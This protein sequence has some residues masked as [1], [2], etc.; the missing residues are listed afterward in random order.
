M[1][2]WMDGFR[3]QAIQSPATLHLLLVS[4]IRGLFEFLSLSFPFCTPDGPGSCSYWHGIVFRL[5]CTQLGDPPAPAPG[6][7]SPIF[8]TVAVPRRTV[9][10]SRQKMFISKKMMDERQDR[11]TPSQ[12]ARPFYAKQKAAH[13]G[14]GPEPGTCG[15]HTTRKDLW[16][17]RRRN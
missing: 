16:T 17:S 4:E 7:L 1:L 11:E 15:R 3:T 6:D 5:L 10:F 13:V 9:C 8:V 2:G 12:P 14:A